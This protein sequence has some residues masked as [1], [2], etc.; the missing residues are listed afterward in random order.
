MN[1][2]NGTVKQND[3]AFMDFLIETM[4]DTLKTVSES[5]SAAKEDLIELYGADPKRIDAIRNLLNLTVFDLGEIGNG[6]K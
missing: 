4:V 6:T 3:K 5:L 2:Q 1:G